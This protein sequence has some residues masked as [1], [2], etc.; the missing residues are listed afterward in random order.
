MLLGIRL[1]K[2]PSYGHDCDAGRRTH[3][4]QTNKLNK[5]A[6]ERNLNPHLN[7][8]SHEG[9]ADRYIKFNFS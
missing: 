9:A 3:I 7:L 6:N 1:I 8:A 4:F 2:H 5:E